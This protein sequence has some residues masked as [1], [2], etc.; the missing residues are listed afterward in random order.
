MSQKQKHRSVARKKQLPK[1]FTLFVLALRNAAQPNERGSSL[2]LPIRANDR[3]ATS[4]AASEAP[5]GDFLVAQWRAMR[6]EGVL[7]GRST[8]EG[9]THGKDQANNW[10]KH[11]THSNA[12]F[13]GCSA[14]IILFREHQSLSRNLNNLTIQT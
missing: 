5:G 1:D 10:T 6:V 2:R 11:T 9:E 14:F 3:T 13:E 12:S 8:A 7:R 4:E